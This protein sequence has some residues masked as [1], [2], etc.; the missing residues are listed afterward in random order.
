MQFNLK[1]TG[2]F[3]WAFAFSLNLNAQFTKWNDDPDEA[4]KLAK[5]LYQKADYSLAF[6]LFKT[7]Y[8]GTTYQ[9][10]IPVTVQEESKYYAILSG[11]QLNDETAEKEAITFIDLE[12]NTPRVEMMSYFLGEY[13]YRKNQFAD[14]LTYYEKAEIANLDNNQIAQ[15]KFHQGYVYFTMQRFRDAKPLFDAVRQLPGDPN[16]LAANYYYGF[17]LF[18]EKK[19][20]EALPA[21]KISEGAAPYQQVVPFYIAEIYYFNNDRDQALSY[22]ENTLKKSGTQYYDLRLKQLIG[23]IYFE[24]KDFQSAKPYLEEYVSNTK[25]VSRA[26]LYEL[27]YC[28]YQDKQYRK[29]V[30][31]FKELGGQQDSLAQN[32]MYLLAKSY[33]ELNMKPSA[34]SAF[35]FCSLNSSNLA[36]KEISKFNYGKLSYELGY[37]DVAL[38]ELKEYVAN[39]PRGENNAEAKELLV[40]VMANTNNFKDA[41]ALL[42]STGLQTEA[43][44]KVYPRILLGRAEE[45]INDP[46]STGQYFAGPGICGC[47]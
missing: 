16:Y 46:G 9:G 17:I 31:G 26:D 13:Y 36:Q 33:L 41:L 45:L 2:F 8:T 4:F 23:H 37:T 10:N 38:N 35:L 7:L 20:T 3:L 21:F 5:D 27:S 22:A 11:L 47:L 34:R 30:E 12:T 19:Y 18:S 42:Q 40:R 28:Y 24:K 15:M 6:P 29:A 1:K 14:A 32:S 43:V 39:Y 44:K 25:K